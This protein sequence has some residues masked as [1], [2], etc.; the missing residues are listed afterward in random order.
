M[1]AV[2]SAV[3]PVI[4]SP[5][6]N[7]PGRTSVV[8]SGST[9]TV[10]TYR[11]QGCQVQGT[12][13]LFH[14]LNRNADGYRNDARPLA[15]RLC[16]FVAAPL[17]DDHRFPTWRYQRG[18]V[19]DHE[20]IQP[21]RSWTVG[22]VSPLIR[23]VQDQAATT[24]LPFYLAGHSAGARFLS[25]VAAYTQSGA[26]R[27]LIANPSTYV[28]PSTTEDAPYGFGRLKSGD[29]LLRAYLTKPVTILLGEEDTGSKNLA[30]SDAAMQQGGTRLERGRRTFAA[31]QAAAL[32]HGW[33][34]GWRLVEVPGIGHNARSMLGGHEAAEALAGK[35]SE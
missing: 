16:L 34:F 24:G 5:I 19:V 29:Q 3:V 10:F 27:I 8:A 14:G 4:S 18:G 12:L 33:A 22:L 32:A 13:I 17:F 11:P 1:I 31:A 28:L 20:A 25:R 2:P 21:E 9:L 30:E 23:A 26:T 7:G 35:P 15:N 6:Q